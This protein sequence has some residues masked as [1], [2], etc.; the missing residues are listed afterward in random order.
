MQRNR[1]S[2]LNAVYGEIPYSNESLQVRPVLFGLSPN[3][4]KRGID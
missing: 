3:V 4:A 2:I 1:A